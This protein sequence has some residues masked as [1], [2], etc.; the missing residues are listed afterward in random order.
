M[1]SDEKT[2]FVDNR[3]P[4]ILIDHLKKWIEKENL[5][6]VVESVQ[7]EHFD[8]LYVHDDKR[9]GWELKRVITD[10]QVVSNETNRT[11]KQVKDVLKDEECDHPKFNWTIGDPKLLNHTKKK[12]MYTLKAELN[13][14]SFSTDTIENNYWAAFTIIRACQFYEGEKE[15]VFKIYC[16]PVIR[17]DKTLTKMMKQCR[18]VGD[19]TASDAGE[20]FK[21]FIDMLLTKEQRDYLLKT[22]NFG[23]LYKKV[24]NFAR[25]SAKKKPQKAPL[26]NIV[27]FIDWFFGIDKDSPNAPLLHGV[28]KGVTHTPASADSSPVAKPHARGQVEERDGK[29]SDDEQSYDDLLEDT[30]FPD[31]T[32]DDIED[33]E[34]K[35]SEVDLTKTFGKHNDKVDEDEIIESIDDLFEEDGWGDTE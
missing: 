16:N 5:N 17:N 27:K 19:K 15:V 32:D 7:L 20:N 28:D 30:W 13:M 9:I 21:N 34:K 29:E 31:A 4:P 25:V 6:I 2:I 8:V 10:D 11:K 1:E 12:G 23:D 3:E 33:I 22:T 35:L 18:N 24:S 26:Q 14:L